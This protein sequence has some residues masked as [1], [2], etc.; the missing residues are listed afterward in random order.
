MS[1]GIVERTGPV[2]RSA[3]RLSARPTPASAV[4]ALIA[5]ALVAGGVVALVHL[6]VDPR[7]LAESSGNAVDFID[8]VL[9]LQPPPLGE[10]VR[11]TVRTLSIV[12][13]ATVLSVL[14]SVPVAVLAARNT[15][16][17]RGGRIGSRAVIVAA[18]A[19]PDL[20]LA[21]VFFRLFGLGALTG[22]L[23]MGLHSVG[24]VGKLYAD[25]IE[26]IDEG[27][28]LALRAAGAGP[29]QQLV[30][31]VLPQVLPSFVATALHRFDINLRVSVLLGYIGVDG[32]GYAI[33]QDIRRLNYHEGMALALIVLVL[34][35]VVEIVSGTIRR[36][37]LRPGATP[38]PRTGRRAQWPAQRIRGWCYGALT[39]A[40]IVAGIYGADLNPDGIVTALG[41][42]GQTLALFWPPSTGG[43]FGDLLDALWVTVEIALAGTLLGAVLALPVGA[44]AASNVTPAPWLGRAC[45]AFLVFVRGIPELVLAIVF[46]V[47]SGMG[48]VAGVLALAVGVVGLL[49]KLVADSLEEV[50]RGCEQALRAT[51]AGHW[52]VFWA[53]TV[54]QAAPAMA[55]HLLYQLDCN[56]RSATL[57]GIV[58]AGGIGYDLLNAARVLEFQVVTTIL[59]LVFAVVLVVEALSSWVRRLLA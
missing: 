46:V 27:P 55:G 36:A 20:V 17:W 38:R 49:G 8:R 2:V 51:G 11:L 43:I 25:A 4:A 45:R 31:G 33:A 23:A 44:L 40:V 52:Q 26:Q 5:V 21:I 56:I 22:V 47:I 42:L 19:L 18:R 48:A 1:I 34:C 3:G 30:S 9:P 6:G 12:L 16:P 50:D 39:A 13:C 59:L 14:L 41:R 54:P 15:G 53:A 7:T 57:L 37:L 28:R 24:M 29:V 58:G 10:V 32:L 35:I